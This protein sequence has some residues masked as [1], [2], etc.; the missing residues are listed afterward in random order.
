MGYGFFGPSLG[1]A[2]DVSYHS[3]LCFLFTIISSLHL[4]NVQRTGFR[5]YDYRPREGLFPPLITIFSAPNYCDMYNNRAA[6]LHLTDEG[7]K[8]EQTTWADHPFHLPS[9]QNVFQYALPFLLDYVSLFFLD[10]LE[11]IEE[12]VGDE[13][14][15]EMYQKL[16][17][18]ICSVAHIALAAKKLQE[19]KLKSIEETEESLPE[20]SAQAYEVAKKIDEKNEGSPRAM[21]ELFGLRGRKLN[22]I[23]E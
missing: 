22:S 11:K 14:E 20:D 5:E 4:G 13:L 15:D 7:Y 16:R 23:N 3:S 9:F 17:S 18:Q 8:I 12:E 10:L 1:V 6:Y 19:E 21:C 2:F